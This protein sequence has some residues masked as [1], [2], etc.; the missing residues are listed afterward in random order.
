MSKFPY[1]PP[2][3]RNGTC[4]HPKGE[5]GI[6]RCTFYRSS[7][8]LSGEC[9]HAS[10][11]LMCG[12]TH[13]PTVTEEQP[14]RADATA[15]PAA[16]ALPTTLTSRWGGDYLRGPDADYTDGPACTRTGCGQAP[17]AHLGWALRHLWTISDTRPV[18]A[19]PTEVE[20]AATRYADGPGCTPA[21][22][23]SPAP[24]GFPSEAALLRALHADND[25]QE[26]NG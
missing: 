6:P 16:P 9:T 3:C 7:R 23:F 18:D 17:A 12:T 4:K 10:R 2:E 8:C 21:V 13:A 22:V 19:P 1:L 14:T 11:N 15:T 25:D 24:A 5:N 20:E 26:D